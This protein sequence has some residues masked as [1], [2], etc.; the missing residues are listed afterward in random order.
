MPLSIKSIL[1]LPNMM[2]KGKNS[3]VTRIG[4]STTSLRIISL[5]T[6]INAEGREQMTCGEPRNFSAEAQA[7]QSIAETALCPSLTE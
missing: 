4:G 6:V 7:N 3:T 2:E 1:V 5:A